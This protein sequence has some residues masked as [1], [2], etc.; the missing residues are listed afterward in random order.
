MTR[1]TETKPTCVSDH[2]TNR[3]DITAPLP[4]Y[5]L[6]ETVLETEG[7]GRQTRYDFVPLSS[8]IRGV[9]SLGAVTSMDR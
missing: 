8:M 4:R 3:L 6:D 7:C 2:R 9:V 1:S 5:L